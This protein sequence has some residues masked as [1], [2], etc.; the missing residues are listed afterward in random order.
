MPSSK[1]KS[2]KSKAKPA[3]ASVAATVSKPIMFGGDISV[4]ALLAEML[5]TFAL[6]AAVLVANGSPLIAG[7]VVLVMVVAFGKISGGHFNPAVSLGLFFTRKLSAWRTAG[8]IV[9]QIL[10]AVLALMIVTK[11]ITT[12]TPMFDQTTGATMTQAY[13]VKVPAG[14]WEQFFAEALGALI[15]GFGIGAIAYAKKEGL[16]AG[17]AAGVSLFI[18]LVVATLGS[19][20]VLNP[21]VALGVSAYNNNGWTWI[22]YALGPIVGMTVGIWLFK[23][24]QW[25]AAERRSVKA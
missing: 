10:G 11:F 3:S 23:L 17:F 14:E 2:S 18:G 25:D 8:Y 21:A 4:G 15:F 24:M 19:A 9:A 16:E 12:G 5:G 6:T 22:A 20:A 7:M 13:A 1:A